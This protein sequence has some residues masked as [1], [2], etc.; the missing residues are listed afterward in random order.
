MCIQHALDSSV[1]ELAFWL[2]VQP[3]ACPEGLAGKCS[4]PLKGLGEPAVRAILKQAGQARLRRKAEQLQA[5]ARQAGW[6]SALWE[7]LFAALGYKRNVWPMRRL[8]QLR[9]AV[10]AGHGAGEPALHIQ[11]RLF[12]IA[13]FLPAEVERSSAGSGYLQSLWQ[14]WWRESAQ[15]R[16][17]VFTPGFWNL[18]GTRPA[19][20]PQ[21]RIALAAHWLAA[22]SLPERLQNWL[23]RQVESPDLF[24]SLA[25]ILEPPADDFWGRRATFRSAPGKAPQQ[26][27]G[28]QRLT[29]LAMNAVLPWLYVRACAG[30]NE[31]LASTAEARYLLWPSGEDNAVLRLA[32]DRLFRGISAKF[33]KSA[34]EQQGLMQIVSDFCNHSNAAC[35]KCLFPELV[36]K[37]V[38]CE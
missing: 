11:A 31:R 15:F 18:G 30:A 4:G 7:G 3:K 27:L 37:I 1:G 22:K 19:N 23:E 8:A 33:L 5:R 24:R 6:E 36:T 10:C 26:L 34:A 13:G 16:E 20:H 38:V 17:H 2:G 9:D 28:E 21:R 12:G 29:D 35:E 14:V 32:R 25:E